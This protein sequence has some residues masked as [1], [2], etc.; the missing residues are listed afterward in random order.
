M[1][2]A[3]RITTSMATKRVAAKKVQKKVQKKGG[4][5]GADRPVWFPG[6][7]SPPWLDGAAL[8]SPLS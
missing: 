4:G 2:L 3:Q 6:A 7:V 8:L 5:G 1:V